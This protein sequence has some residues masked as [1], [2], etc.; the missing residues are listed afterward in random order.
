[1]RRRILAALA[2]IAVTGALGAAT[3]GPVLAKSGTAVPN[4]DPGTRVVHVVAS[5]DGDP[6]TR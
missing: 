1:M 2:S 3:A 6:G 5:P 4:G